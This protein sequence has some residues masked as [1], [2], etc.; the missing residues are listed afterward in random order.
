MAILVKR[1]VLMSG[2]AGDFYLV[3][4]CENGVDEKIEVPAYRSAI[5]KQPYEVQLAINLLQNLAA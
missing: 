2:C 3:K 1:V 5:E 4:I